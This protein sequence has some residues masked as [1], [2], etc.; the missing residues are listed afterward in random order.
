LRKFY[1]L[2]DRGEKEHTNR[3]MAYYPH[4]FS[5]YVIFVR[6]DWR[7]PR[8][9]HTHTQLFPRRAESSTAEL[10]GPFRFSHSSGAGAR[11]L[12]F[13]PGWWAGRGSGNV[14]TLPSAIPCWT[15]DQQAEA[16]E[17]L[18]WMQG[19]GAAESQESQSQRELSGAAGVC[20]FGPPRR[21]PFSPELSSHVTSHVSATPEIAPLGVNALLLSVH[22]PSLSHPHSPALVS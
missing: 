14:N 18:A 12:V 5:T 3:G 4:I 22:A 15:I 13:H 7:Y 1:F 17:A 20:R 21:L 9:T 2:S 16:D 6:S 11:C 8:H 10:V 19:G